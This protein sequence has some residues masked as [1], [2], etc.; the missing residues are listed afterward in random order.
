M[1]SFNFA[2][3]EF[4]RLLA[5]MPVLT[6]LQRKQKRE[7]H[8]AM[9]KSYVFGTYTHAP[10]PL[11]ERDECSCGFYLGESQN[12]RWGWCDEVEG[13]GRTINHKGWYLDD[14]GI[15][16]TIRGMVFRLPHSRGFLIGWSMG[17]GMAGTIYYRTTY[18]TERDA[19]YAADR[20]AE[21]VA[22]EER[23]YRRKDR[24][25][26]ELTEALERIDELRT[27]HHLF[28]RGL[29]GNKGDAYVAMLATERAKEIRSE[30][31]KHVKTIRRLRGD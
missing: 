22:E 4:P 1:N 28:W 9:Y 6:N 29:S 24:E 27:K 5:V 12:L 31:S 16:E 14:E 26:Q 3:F 7:A 19:A 10:T 30:V 25:E 15:D 17:K 21:I 8:G 18:E 23:D 20:I 11:H 13:V 2:S